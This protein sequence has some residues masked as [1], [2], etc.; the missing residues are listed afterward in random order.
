M[1]TYLQNFQGWPESLLQTANPVERIFAD[2]QFQEGRH[3]DLGDNFNGF[4]FIVED[5]D[6]LEAGERNVGDFSEEG[7]VI[8]IILMG[9]HLLA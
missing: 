2:D 6:F 5:E 1:H 3:V 9:I 8:G 4:K 7:L